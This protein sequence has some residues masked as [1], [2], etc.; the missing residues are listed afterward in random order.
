MCT[1]LL[2]LFY[3]EAVAVV[4][5]E[6]VLHQFVELFIELNTAMLCRMVE[7]GN[8]SAVHANK[9]R[10]IVYKYY[11]AAKKTRLIISPVLLKS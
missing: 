1:N 5:F 8:Y 7:K 11:A 3:A 10:N 6:L 2:F 9:R 4:D